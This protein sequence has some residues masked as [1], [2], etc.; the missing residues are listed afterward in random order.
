M[1]SPVLYPVIPY[2]AGTFSPCGDLLWGINPSFLCLRHLDLNR[3]YLGADPMAQLVKARGFLGFS[4]GDIYTGHELTFVHEL[5]KQIAIINEMHDN[6][7]S[8]MGTNSTSHPHFTLVYFS[9]QSVLIHTGW[10]HPSWR[11]LVTGAIPQAIC[12]PQNEQGPCSFLDLDPGS[13][14]AIFSC[15]YPF[16]RKC[17]H[18]C[19]I[20][21][22]NAHWHT[23]FSGV[24]LS[25]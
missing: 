21:L 25:V 8:Q 6:S 16:S 4:H 19:V 12:W 24:I 5:G 23:R 11:P 7:S 13:V 9:T 14:R 18:F 3:G 22:G 20:V 15:F 10:W 1:L 2:C 17:M